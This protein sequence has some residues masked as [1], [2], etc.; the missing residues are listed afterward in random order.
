MVKRDMKSVAASFLLVL[1][2][3]S[4]AHAFVVTPSQRVQSYP[5][6]STTSLKAIPEFSN[7]FLLAD[8][9]SAATYMGG[10]NDDLSAASGALS[11]LRNFFIV[12]TAAI[13]G[14]TAIVYLTAAFLVPKAAEQLERDT[15][16]LN[17]GLWLEYEQK[18]EPGESM[19]NVRFHVLLAY[20]ILMINICST[21]LLRIQRPDLLQEL[22]NIMQPI[23]AADYEKEAAMKFDA[24]Y[25]SNKNTDSAE[26][27]GA[28]S[29]GSEYVSSL[30]DPSER[31]VIDVTIKQQE[32]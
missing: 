16:R 30:K 28:G 20:I 5:T 12:G 6:S 15:R 22:G 27:G 4:V 23:I 32:D 2:V 29:D 9:L 10:V 14:I 11:T 17:P 13:F 25:N 18:L 26:G 19:V 21:F 31:S 7:P 3:A 24:K 1:A 8:G